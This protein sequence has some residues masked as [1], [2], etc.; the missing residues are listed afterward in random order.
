MEK[1]WNEQ[2]PTA[3]GLVWCIIPSICVALSTN[4]FMFYNQ[5]LVCLY[6]EASF[7]WWKETLGLRSKWVPPCL[8]VRSP[9]LLALMPVGRSSYF[10]WMLFHPAICALQ[11]PKPFGFFEGK[12]LGQ[13]YTSPSHGC[14]SCWF[15]SNT[16]A[17]CH[18]TKI[19]FIYQHFTMHF[20]DTNIKYIYIH[21]FI[22]GS[23]HSGE[24]QR[25]GSYARPTWGCGG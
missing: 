21:L 6:N 1:P 10:F 22:W 16:C 11:A 9:T 4:I 5:L 19:C 12:H 15:D 17:L 23:Q 18:L 24:A 14:S 25:T 3:V 2:W 8:K 13:P 7:L 20:R